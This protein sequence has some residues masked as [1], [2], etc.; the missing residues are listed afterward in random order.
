MPSKAAAAAAA[1]AVPGD[2]DRLNCAKVMLHVS[3]QLKSIKQRT[4]L[5]LEQ[6]GRLDRSAAES[7]NRWMKAR[8]S[9]M[10]NRYMVVSMVEGMHA[11]TYEQLTACMHA[12]MNE[13][14]RL[15]GC[16]NAWIARLPCREP[17]PC[18]VQAALTVAAD[19]CMNKRSH[20]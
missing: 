13:C 5:R 12:C 8:N 10:L 15:I 19:R 18:A 14:I 7:Y 6:G 3:K 11:L 17:P 1:A 4:L 20:T 9:S 16:A 2:Q